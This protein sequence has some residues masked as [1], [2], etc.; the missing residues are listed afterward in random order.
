[1]P[2]FQPIPPEPEPSPNSE[3][4]Q[5]EQRAL[6]SELTADLFPNWPAELS[7]RQR[8]DLLSLGISPDDRVTDFMEAVAKARPT[9]LDAP[10]K[11]ER[12]IENLAVQ[13]T[14]PRNREPLGRLE[15]ALAGIVVTFRG[16]IFE[17]PMG[18][19]GEPAVRT[20][21]AQAVWQWG[22]DAAGEPLGH[23]LSEN[24]D[25]YEFNGLPIAMKH[26]VQ[27]SLIKR[28]VQW[29]ESIL[30]EARATSAT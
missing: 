20:N 24:I 11:G 4:V 19:N 23:V 5:V 29:R 27:N 28:F 17:I 3:I 1:M 21:I 10:N 7:G 12:P 14:I 16:M 25:P 22:V 15:L 18:P 13:V 30:D 2:V 8:L 6:G 26:A 9:V